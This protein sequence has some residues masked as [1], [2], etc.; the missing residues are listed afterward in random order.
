MERRINLIVIH[1]SDSPDN[2]DIGFKEIDA[3]HKDRWS[4]VDDNGRRIYCGY[5]WIIRRSGTVERGRP[6]HLIGAHAT[7]Y[8]SRSLGIC[9]VGRKKI[10]DLQWSNLV[11]LTKFL[12]K[13]YSIQIESVLGHNELPKVEKTCPNL[14]M[15]KLRSDIGYA[16]MPKKP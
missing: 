2:L 7:G 9:W 16:L 15:D 6:E 13:K 3:W 8:N 12:M 10:D 11:N 5:H 14:S 4:G 1:T